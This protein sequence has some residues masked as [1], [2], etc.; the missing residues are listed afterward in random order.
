MIIIASPVVRSVGVAI[1]IA[2]TFGTGAPF[3]FM[4]YLAIR[5]Y[6]TDVF[7]AAHRPHDTPIPRG[8]YDFIVVGAGSAGAVLANRLSEVTG[9]SILLLEA[10][11][12]EPSLSD[13]PA[14]MPTLQ[15][16]PL[17]W[18]YKTEYTG[19]ACLAMKD[20]VCS[21]PRGKCLGGSSVLNAMLYIRGN[22]R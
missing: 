12:P 20:Q 9:W 10:G 11:G 13:I 21:W 17:D 1:R 2:L 22:R 4:M 15:H 6:R 14:F 19:D 18:N 7:D 5:M 16:S 8:R 3:I